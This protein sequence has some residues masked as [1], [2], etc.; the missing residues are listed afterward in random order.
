[1]NQNFRGWA[2]WLL[3][4]GSCILLF[5]RCANIVPPSGGPKDTTAPRIVS[6]NPLDS[7]LHF[8][9]KKVV[10]TF[11]EYVELDN[12]FEKLIVSPTLKRTPTVTSKLHTVTMVIKDTLEANTTYTFNFSDAIRD[13]NERN[14]IK[15]YSYVVSTGDYLD[16]LQVK[17]FIIDAE[18]GKPDSNVS[19]MMY[20]HSQDS[21]VSKEKPV[22]YARSKG[23]GGFWFKN[24]APGDYKLFALKEEDK[25]LQYNQPAE[26]IAFADSL[27]RIR[28]KNI[29]DLPLLLFLEQDSTL[30][31][32]GEM[33]NEPP[34]EEDNKE[35]EKEKEKEKKKKR[36]LTV[37]PVLV[38]AHQELGQPLLITFN[39]RITKFD[40]TT[41]QLTQDTINTP[42]KFVTSFD[43]T[44]TKLS[45]AYDWKEGTP[46]RLIIPK[47]SLSD[48]TGLQLT[49]ADT[50][51][52][53]SKKESDYGKAMVT[54]QLS[55]STKAAV[56][57]TMHYVAELIKDKEVKYSGKLVNG[58]WTQKRIQPGEYEV[59][60]LLDTNNNG[61]WDRGVYYGTPKKQPERVVSFP[62]KE[63][64]KA[65]W[66]VPIRLTL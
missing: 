27:V 25:D 29:N 55:D 49:K 60:I 57:D 14:P 10:L 41:F 24:L 22:Y 6:A 56:S 19:V 66:G 28:E 63:N 36:R 64:I 21:V 44:R 54:L 62:K 9:S 39:E 65:N 45:I 31:K 13:I 4:I 18:T 12:I 38:D 59:W 26:L 20:R 30:K 17:G 58:G 34:P 42:V 47:E 15:E 53:V 50:I 48:S 40:S 37:T 7:T 2:S 23:N 3:I 32:P 51:K 16:S 8:K 11:D 43:S 61:K 33:G 52:F 35:K 5:P 1:M 46:Y